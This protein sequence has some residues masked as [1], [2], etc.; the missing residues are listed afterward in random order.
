M[1]FAPFTA[2]HNQT[3]A[4]HRIRWLS[5]TGRVMFLAGVCILGR[6]LYVW[7]IQGVRWDLA[8]TSLYSIFSPLLNPFASRL[9][10]LVEFS[11]TVS[12]S[13]ILMAL[14]WCSSHL[15]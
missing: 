7:I 6:D 14:G 3:T 4:L 9:R 1:G 13:L 10:N 11:R 5:V 2:D 8:M 12:L 15:V